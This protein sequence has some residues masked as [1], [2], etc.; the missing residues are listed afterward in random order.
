MLL[1]IWR[2]VLLSTPGRVASTRYYAISRFPGRGRP[3][4]A[5][6]HQPSP[7]RATKPQEPQS[8]DT[9]KSSEGTS[10]D[11]S[12]LWKVGDSLDASGSTDGLERLLANDSLVVERQIEMLNIFIGFEQTNKYSITNPAGEQVGFIAEEPGGFLSSFNRQ[13]LS[14]HRPFKA[15]VMDPSG[16]PILWV[17]RPFA[18]INSRMYV[19]RPHPGQEASGGSSTVLDTFAEVQQIWHPFRRK[20]DLF[21]RD[22][23]KRIL[24]L[25]SDPQPEPEPETDTF[26]QIAKVDA[27]FLAWDFSIQDAHARELAFISRNFRGFGRE[28]FTDTGRYLLHFGLRPEVDATDDLRYRTKTSPLNLEQRALI[29]ALAVNI[30]F[31]YFSRHSG[32]PGFF[33]FGFW[34]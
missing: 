2:R 28:I 19:Q 7:V 5:G 26:S 1:Q 9:T 6:R 33:H 20:Y 10:V 4:G 25:A 8:V 23:P 17:R 13:I 29:L 22:S 14:T 21:L 32:G 11:E 24:S 16:T 34:E 31:D 30:D 27:P 18:W 15:L 3:V 12:T